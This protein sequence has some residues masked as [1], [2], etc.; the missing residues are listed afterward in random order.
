MLSNPL[1][2]AGKQTLLRA[3]MPA[4]L[5][6]EKVRQSFGGNSAKAVQILHQK[7]YMQGQ[8][9]LHIWGSTRGRHSHVGWES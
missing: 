5:S 6:V 7:P 4:A 3:C 8:Y 9:V 2:T 1:N